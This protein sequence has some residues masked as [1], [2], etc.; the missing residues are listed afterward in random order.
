MKC[1]A[2]RVLKVEFYEKTQFTQFSNLLFYNVS[3]CVQQPSIPSPHPTVRI[4]VR[5]FESAFYPHPIANPWKGVC[6]H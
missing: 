5:Q 2:A 6:L 4:R 3:L 1:E